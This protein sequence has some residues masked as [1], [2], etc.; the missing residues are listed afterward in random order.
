MRERDGQ[1]SRFAGD[2]LCCPWNNEFG[3]TRGQLLPGV[4]YGDRSYSLR[5]NSMANI[6]EAVKELVQERN[7]MAGQVRK[8]DEAISVLRKL[9]GSSLSVMRKSVRKRRTM[10]AAARRKI[11]AAQKAR[12]AKWKQKQIKKAA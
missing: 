4:Y 12:W 3:E 9:K 5:G 8:L 2:G 6:A 7:R 10:S 11:S 1:D